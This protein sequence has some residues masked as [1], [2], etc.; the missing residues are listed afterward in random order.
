MN[1]LFVVSQQQDWPFDM[2]GISAI[3]AHSYLTDP[4]YGDLHCTK[5]FNLCRNY[6]YQNYGYYVSLLAEARGHQPLPDVEAIR[7]LQ[8]AD[9]LQ[10]AQARLENLIQC[11]LFET[12]RAALE[13]DIYFGRDP[14]GRHE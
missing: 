4:A 9:L 2:P 12:E 13:L 8:A 6:R 1:I 3:T 11:S 7:S 5:V 10:Q 14:T